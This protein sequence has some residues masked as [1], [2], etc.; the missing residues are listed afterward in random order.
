MTRAI[1]RVGAP[2]SPADLDR[3]YDLFARAFPPSYHEAQAHLAFIRAHQPPVPAENYVVAST[4][5][6]T[7]V[8]GLTLLERTMLVDG[9]PMRVAGMSYYAIEPSYQATDCAAR[10]IAATFQRLRGGRYDLAV[11]FARKVMDGYWSR[12]GF[13]GFTG[14]SSL[15]VEA[16]DLRR[17]APAGTV[18]AVPDLPEPAA[19]A[20]LYR[21]T[22]GGLTG[23]FVREAPE[24]RYWTARVRRGNLGVTTFARGGEA[25]GYAIRRANTV[26]E[27]AAE[28]QWLPACLRA[29]G[30]SAG[31]GSLI[32]ACA[33]AHPAACVL[34]T[35]NHAYT[36]RRAWNGGHIALVVDR[37]ALLERLRPAIERRLRGAVCAPFGVQ[38]A[39]VG[40]RWDGER[41][42]FARPDGVK[43][44]IAFEP[45]E[46]TKLLLGVE[47]PEALRGFQD[48]GGARLASVLFP[49]LWPQV[50]ELDEF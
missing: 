48:E 41:V 49:V 7:I 9:C 34:R 38:C 17:L 43:P 29:L 37:D 44:A 40:V 42:A 18:T 11:G 14:F 45:S 25:V 3:L 36:V 15:T 5:D 19:L 2:A 13:V 23:A 35:L 22:Y 24:W 8:G 47:P 20:R 10:I 12:H 46:W 16:P 33:P 32:F 21:A 39:D 4:A 27:I 30:E 50:A 26:L 1:A 6:G 31:A 28:P